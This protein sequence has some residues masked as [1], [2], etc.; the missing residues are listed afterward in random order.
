MFIIY[1]NHLPDVAE[2]KQNVFADDSKVFEK[3]NEYELKSNLCK[4][5]KI[6]EKN[7]LNKE[8]KQKMFN[9]LRDIENTISLDKRF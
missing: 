8:Q 9:Y 2:K 7:T 3:H 1:I 6:T 5:K 4:L